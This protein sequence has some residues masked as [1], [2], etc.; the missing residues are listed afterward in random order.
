[1]ACDGEGAVYRI[2]IEDNALVIE[3]LPSQQADGS[4]IIVA[5]VEPKTLH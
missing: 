2:V 1:M 5:P 3:E 4:M